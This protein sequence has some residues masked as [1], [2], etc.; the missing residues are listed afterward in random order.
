MEEAMPKAVLMD[1]EAMRRALTRMAHEIMEHEALDKVLLVGIRRRG[2]PLA[3][4]LA[5]LI[6]TFEH[7]R[8]PTGA[9]D[10]T[11]YRDDR[12][13][14]QP[15]PVDAAAGLPQ[16]IH[17]STVILVDDVLY[18]GRTVRAAMEAVMAQG[19]PGRIRLAVL[20]DRGHR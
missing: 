2:V 9:L 16:N 8:I 13:A 20:I 10:I 18:T 3:E 19:R 6:A 7:I 1:S 15:A 12:Q 5:A 17:G 11:H 4:R 14:A